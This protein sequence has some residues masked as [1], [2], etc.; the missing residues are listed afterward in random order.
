[1]D[2]LVVD[3]DWYYI[4]LGFGGWIGWI[5][6]CRLFFDFVKFLGYLKSNDLKIILN[7]YFVDGVVLYEEKYLEMV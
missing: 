2:V 7:L 5:W 3:M 4:D 6:N 1:M